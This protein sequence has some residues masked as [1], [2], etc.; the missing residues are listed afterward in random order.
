MPGRIPGIDQ[1]IVVTAHDVL[2]GKAWTGTNVVVIGGGS[3]GAETA[4]HLASN[5]KNVTIVEMMDDIASDELVVP[6]WGLLAD[7]KKN[8][9][10]VYTKTKLESIKEDGVELSGTFNGELKADTVV[11]AMGSRP[12][13]TLAE[14]L[15]ETGIDVRVIGDAKSVGLA[16]KAIE[17]GFYLGR[18][19]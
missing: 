15:K 8:N 5:L 7:L 10:T 16:T 4:N 17:E 3:V 12:N 1:D 13:N 2:E 14:Q 19:I 18:E 6:R 9:V 11:L